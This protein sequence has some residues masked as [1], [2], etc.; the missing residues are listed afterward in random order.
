M[1][2]RG[3]PGKKSV[4]DGDSI[5]EPIEWCHPLAPR[6]YM[7]GTFFFCCWMYRERKE[8]RACVSASL[9]SHQFL[10]WVQW[11]RPSSVRLRFNSLPL[12]TQW[13]FLTYYDLILQT[14][15]PTWF[16]YKYLSDY[17]GMK[18]LK[19]TRSSMPCHHQYT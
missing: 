18:W 8:S 1:M 15:W 12:R 9:D 19:F 3:A 11:I 14:S 10:W 6:A 5:D 16:Y 4:G 13:F 2:N 17:T 7:R